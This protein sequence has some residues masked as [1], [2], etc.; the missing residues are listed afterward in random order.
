MSNLESGGLSLFACDCLGA[1]A[2]T[3]VAS[4]LKSTCLV[5]RTEDLRSW[6]ADLRTH[7]LQTF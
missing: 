1:A 4:A 2:L 5:N 7:A 3:L 6:G